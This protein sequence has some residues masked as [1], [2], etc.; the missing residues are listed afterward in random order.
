MNGMMNG[1]AG[2]RAD[3]PAMPQPFPVEN[4]FGFDQAQDQKKLVIF[5]LKPVHDPVKSRE[6]GYP[7]FHDVVFVKMQDPG[8]NLTVI[9]RPARDEDRARFPRHWQMFEAGR[10]GEHPGMLLDRLFPDNPAIV[11]RLKAAAVHTVEQ[12]AGLGAEGQRQVGMGALEWQKKAQAFLEQAKDTAVYTKMDA[13]L[14][15][16]DETISALMEQIGELKALLNRYSGDEDDESP[17]PR[18]G[19][20]PKSATPEE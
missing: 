7:W 15:K 17:R 8:D 4:V 10:G 16:R 13:E 5:Y 3:M 1:M 18:R 11:A 12:L 14:S 19:R 9:D 6:V 2:T 20:P